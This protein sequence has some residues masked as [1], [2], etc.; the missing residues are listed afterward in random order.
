MD[1]QAMAC[2]IP[3]LFFLLSQLKGMPRYSG[4][5]LAPAGIFFK[6]FGQIFGHFMCSVV[7][8]VTFSSNNNYNIIKKIKNQICFKIPK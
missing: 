5:L 7:T 6:L 1:F 8:L 3:D 2:L 4:Q